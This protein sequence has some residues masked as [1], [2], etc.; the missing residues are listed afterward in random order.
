[1]PA[2]RSVSDDDLPIVDRVLAGDTEAFTELVRRNERRVYRTTL[3]ITRNPED[4]EDAMQETFLKAYQ[5]LAEFQRTSRFTT[6]L[7]R[8][9]IN[10]GLQRV[11]RRR[12]TESLDELVSAEEEMMPRQVRDWQD[13][14]EELYAKQEIREF[15]EEAI[16]SLPPLYRVAFILR[17]VEEVSTEEAA[18]V[19]GVSIPALKSRVLRARLMVRELLAKRFQQAPTLKSRIADVGML[20]NQVLGRWSR[21]TES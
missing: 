16:H 7:T 6:W 21:R 8:I 9:A 14:P 18:E 19:L 5:H 3:A 1:M 2:R 4:A 17:D 10:E 11:R 12:P 13:N 20:L 15:V